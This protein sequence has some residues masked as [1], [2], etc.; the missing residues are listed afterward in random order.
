[1]STVV[2]AGAQGALGWYATLIVG[3]AVERW[4]VQGKSWGRDGPKQVVREIVDSL[5]RGSV[6]REAR[7]E[8]LARL[9][10]RQA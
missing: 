6:L 9:R 8:I 5:D 1:L 7:G 2:T 3:R 10:R 4:L